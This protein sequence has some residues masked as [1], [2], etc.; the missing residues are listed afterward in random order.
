MGNLPKHLPSY[1][2]QVNNMATTKSHSIILHLTIAILILAIWTG[3]T[4][5]GRSKCTGGDDCCETI[6]D[7]CHLGG[8]KCVD[9]TYKGKKYTKQDCLS[10]TMGYWCASSVKSNG[11]YNDWDYFCKACE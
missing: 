6:K 9:F 10:G 2:L 11:E 1:T 7:K 5:A 8:K 4:S 3:T